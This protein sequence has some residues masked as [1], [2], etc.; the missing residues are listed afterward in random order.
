MT[1]RDDKVFNKFT[2]A[3]QEK[4]K[5]ERERGNALGRY[6]ISYLLGNPFVTFTIVP[7]GTQW[8]HAGHRVISSITENQRARSNERFTACHHVGTLKAKS[9]VGRIEFHTIRAPPRVGAGEKQRNCFS[10]LLACRRRPQKAN[11]DAS[12]KH[13]HASRDFIL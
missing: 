6:F 7:G 3:T 13:S 8:L 4:R 1:R 10:T 2:T 5:R 11:R 12:A 9:T